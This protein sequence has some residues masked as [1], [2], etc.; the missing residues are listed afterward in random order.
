MLANAPQPA[1]FDFRMHCIRFQRNRLTG[2]HRAF[3][4]CGW[5]AIGPAAYVQA[6]AAT[7]DMDEPPK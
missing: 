4:S 2:E 7:H 3:C 6:R 5:E 1:P